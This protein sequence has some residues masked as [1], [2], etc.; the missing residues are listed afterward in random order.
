MTRMNI[1]W[2]RYPRYQRNPW[3][4]RIGRF[5]VFISVLGLPG[6]GTG[7]GEVQYG[8]M[9][10]PQII[11]IFFQSMQGRVESQQQFAA[12]LELANLC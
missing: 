12:S 7:L 4:K 6:G 1:V 5:E 9:T 10:Q 11:G 3:L 8:A 2:D